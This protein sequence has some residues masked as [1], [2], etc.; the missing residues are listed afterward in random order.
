MVQSVKNY[1]CIFADINSSF[2][3]SLSIF[4]YSCWKLLAPLNLSD[5]QM[6][7]LL[8]ESDDEKR[9]QAWR[10][11]DLQRRLTE[12]LGPSCQVYLAALCALRKRMSK[13]AHKLK[14]GPDFRVSLL[15]DYGLR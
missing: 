5:A 11:G 12:R 14:L 4:E 6:K 15:A 8:S 1:E 7:T 9:R 2:A 3:V 13:L 10:D